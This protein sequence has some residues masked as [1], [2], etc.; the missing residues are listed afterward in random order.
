MKRFL[1]AAL[2]AA[3]CVGFIGI[4]SSLASYT[5]TFD[6][7]DPTVAGLE[8]A[9]IYDDLGVDFLS[10][11]TGLTDPAQ[12]FYPSYI[13][14]GQS[15]TDIFWYPLLD[16]DE[17][18]PEYPYPTTPYLAMDNTKEDNKT[19]GVSIQFDY[20]STQLAF[21]YRRPGSKETT[22]SITI[23]FFDTAA[24]I[25]DD[26]FSDQVT[27]YVY[28]PTEEDTDGDGWLEYTSSQGTPFNLVVISGDKKFAIDDLAVTTEPDVDGHYPEDPIEPGF[29]CTAY[30][31]ANADL[32]GTWTKAECMNHYRLYGFSENRAVAFNLEEYLNANPDL[33]V[34]WTYEEALNHYN[35]Y[36]ITEKRLLAFDA[37]EYLSLNPDLPQEWSYEEAFAHYLNY[38]KD[39]GRIASFDE[40]AYL[41]LYSDLPSSWGQAEAFNHYINYGRNEGRVYDPYDES[42]FLTD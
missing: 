22:G 36:G 40:T 6:D 14:P 1:L 27:A 4:N 19:E 12:F 31:A 34:S 3:M 21:K 33:P 15:V 16:T 30:L 20:Y 8:I 5:I 11:S 42:V 28:A 39:E 41:E 24:S 29:N 32:P 38:G 10:D 23:S 17:D 7:Q 2:M 13:V 9:G 26:L 37:Q 35:S 18:D 25:Q